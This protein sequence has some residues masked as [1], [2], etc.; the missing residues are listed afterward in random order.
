[1]TKPLEPLEPLEPEVSAAPRPGLAG[2]AE[3]AASTVSGGARKRPGLMRVLRYGLVAL[4]VAFLVFAV[5]SQWQRLPEQDWRFEPGWLALSVF[6]F[7]GMLAL[8]AEM[9]RMVL[10]GLGQPIDRARSRQIWASSLLA[11]YVPTNA[12]LIVGRVS[13]AAKEGVPQRICLASI[14]YEV[15]LGVAGALTVGAYAV[16]GLDVLAAQPLRYLVLVLPL[17]ALASLHPAIFHPLANFGLTRIGREPLPRTL[18]PRTLLACWAVS[19][20]M[21]LVAGLGVYAFAKSLYPVSV[22]DLPTLVSSWAVG[23]TVSVLAFV[24]PAG[25]GAREAGLV[26]ALAPVLPTSVA[27]AVTVAARIMVT[28]VELL[29]A[30]LSSLA[31]RGHGYRPPS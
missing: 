30:A 8:N 25:L 4:V 17:A 10:A 3:A 28:G 22:E 14:V 18:R 26:A 23:F 11:R 12:L 16:I 13:M 15:A 19:V 9:W 31:A 7:G 2:R 1:M 21:F 20:T 6:G 24:L 5:A 27:L 29:F